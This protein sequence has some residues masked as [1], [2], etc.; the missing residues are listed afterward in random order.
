MNVSSP[1]FIC[2]QYDAENKN[3]SFLFFY[4][5]FFIIFLFSW[6]GDNKVNVSSQVKF[7]FDAKQTFPHFVRNG[8]NVPVLLLQRG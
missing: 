3:D 1:S 4:H 7:L 6:E 8:G 5:I 2:C